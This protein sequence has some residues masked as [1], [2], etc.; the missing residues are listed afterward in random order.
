MAQNLS[1]TLT[2][3]MW[4]S[5][6]D[7]AG[8]IAWVLQ[9]RPLTSRLFSRTKSHSVSYDTCFAVGQCFLPRDLNAIAQPMSHQRI[10]Q[11]ILQ[12]K[13]QERPTHVQLQTTF[14]KQT[15]E[16]QNQTN[17]ENLDNMD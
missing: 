2:K 1:L 17:G 11:C 8:L 9:S 7:P 4:L 14:S 10:Q 6:T 15:P 12:Q 13:E 16:Q 5:K 3:V